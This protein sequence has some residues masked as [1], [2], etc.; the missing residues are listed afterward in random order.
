MDPPT[1]DHVPTPAL[2]IDSK[3]VLR[4]LQRMAEYGLRYELDMRPHTKTHKSRQMAE[5][6]MEGGA[7]GL[8]A[9]KVG[10]AEMMSEV[11]S[12]ILL[13]YPAIDPARTARLAKLA[14]HVTVRV[15]V[16]STTGVKLIAAAANRAKATV[17]ILVDLDVG[18]GRTGVQTAN[19]ALK[20]AQVVDGTPGVRFDGLFC[21]PGHIHLPPDE[22]GPL[23]DAVSR[24]LGQTLDLWA[25]HGLQ[26]RIVSGGSTPTAF[27]SHLVGEYTEI[28]PG[29][30]IYNDINTVRGGYCQLE[31]CAASIIST[32]ISTA[33]PGQ[34]VL[35]AGTKTLTS[36]RCSYD[37]ESGHG[38]IVE[39]PQAVIGKLTE[40]HAQVDVRKCDRVPEL[41]QRVTVIP[42][43]VCPCIN[44]QDVVWW[45]DEGGQLVDLPIDA[46]GLLV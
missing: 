10:E 36:D 43:H 30:Y 19:Q 42:N 18:M 39:Y 34:V 20:L 8:S 3:T 14:S 45:H 5:L 11:A 44:L 17:G 13:A 31:D 41:G 12:D 23:L 35:D 46:R 40:E 7:I 16:D 2:V 4:N 6:Q 15:A 38:Y 1:L 37:P 26:A 21:Y 28:R 22:Q 29:T 33:V 32:V 24:K 27:Q 25:E 9:A